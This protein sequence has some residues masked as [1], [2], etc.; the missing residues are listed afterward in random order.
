MQSLRAC[1][2]LCR[3]QPLRDSQ[4]LQPLCGRRRSHRCRLR[5]ATFAIGRRRESLRGGEAMQPLQP[6][7][8]RQSL[9]SLQS[10]RDREAVQPM[11]SLHRSQSLYRGKSLQPLQPLWARRGGRVN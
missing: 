3:G 11:Q 6:L 7:R 4:P 9:Q 1:Q 8:R 2:S 5:R 10:L